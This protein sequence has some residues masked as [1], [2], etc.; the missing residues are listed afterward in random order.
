VR[1]ADQAFQSGDFAA[2]RR[3]LEQLILARPDYAEAH[4]YLGFL[5]AHR[6][7][8][9]FVADGVISLER[10][11]ALGA[12]WLRL[13]NLGDAL[14]AAGRTD[15][16]AAAYRRSLAVAQGHPPLALYGLAQC[17]ELDGALLDALGL[18]RAAAAAD[19]NPA[20][21]HAIGLAGKR[22][23]AR[24]RAAGRYFVSESE[25]DV[26]DRADPAPE[27]PTEAIAAALAAALPRARAA[28]GQGQVT[29][30]SS[31]VA[32]LDAIAACLAAGRPLPDYSA[33]VFLLGRFAA[34]ELDGSPF[35][36]PADALS[37]VSHL[38]DRLRARWYRA[39]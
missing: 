36:E 28:L 14:F 4:H 3:E 22:V 6:F 25:Q 15:E 5:L 8:R 13:Q 30:E 1:T 35:A 23:E 18:Y 27:E 11:V 19:D 24:L 32:Q 2:A 12:T 10:A 33:R 21:Q 7:D 26:V 31:V 39:P 38:W 29:F 16:A 17:R 37:Q 20:R 34:R 9:L